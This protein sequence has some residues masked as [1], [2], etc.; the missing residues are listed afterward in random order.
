MEYVHISG[1]PAS[2][3]SSMCLMFSKEILLEG[4]RVF[5]LSPDIHH[6]PPERFAQIMQD[7][8]ISN[9][10]KF[11]SLNFS[12]RTSFSENSFEGAITKLMVMATQLPSTKIIIIEDWEYYGKAGALNKIKELLEICKKNKI[13][14]FLTSICYHDASNSSKKYAIRSE[15]KFEKMGFENW[16]ISPHEDLIT[17]ERISKLNK[18]NEE[19]LFKI[20]NEGIEYIE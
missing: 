15:S 17:S 16:L 3:K 10:S 6:I 9:A 12:D 7:L 4:G 11:H 2:G 20:T 19:I 18:P 8:P 14:L 1:T 5:W 13:K